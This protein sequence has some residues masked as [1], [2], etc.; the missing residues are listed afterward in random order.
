MNAVIQN[1]QVL[2]YVP[3]RWRTNEKF[4]LMAFKNNRQILDYIPEELT[5]NRE[6]IFK[7]LKLK[8]QSPES[9]DYSMEDLVNYI[10][11]IKKNE[12]PFDEMQKKDKKLFFKNEEILRQETTLLEAV[13]CEP[14]FLQY[15]RN[16][17]WLFKE[18]WKFCAKA[19]R[20]GMVLEY[21]YE[22]VR[23]DRDL[24]AIAVASDG[25]AFEFAYKELKKDKAT[26]LNMVK[27]SGNALEFACDELKDDREIVLAAVRNDGKALKFANNRFRVIQKLFWKQSYH[28]DPN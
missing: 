13:R 28:A 2:K 14:Q 21:L 17:L 12:F 20:N 4:V 27:R 26:V 5:S 7:L 22:V 8:S 24:V 1:E 25:A 9:L 3:T 6:F 18:D 23:R 11:L 10:P 19:L 15:V 16:E